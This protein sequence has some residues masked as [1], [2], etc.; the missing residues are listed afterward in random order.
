MGS[1]VDLGEVLKIKVR[2][3]LCRGNICMA[4][5]LLNAAQVLARFQQ[6]SGERMTKHVR[7]D[8]YAQSLPLR[9]FADAQLN[10]SRSETCAAMRDKQRKLTDRC[11]RC[12]FA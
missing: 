5:Q 9:P 7:V 8:V 1:V 6:M 11:N 3:H 12:T 10:C 4:E 2:V